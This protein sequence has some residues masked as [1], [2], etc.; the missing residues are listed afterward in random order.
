[1]DT[2]S[3]LRMAATG[4]VDARD[5]AWSRVYDEV[6]VVARAQRRRWSGDWTMETRVLANEVFI[7]VFGDNPPELKDRKHFFTLL[8]KAVRQILVN[9]S[10]SRRAAKRGGGQAQV[11]LSE[12]G[13]LSLEPEVS[14]RILDLHAALKRFESLDERAARIV[15]LRFFA[16][17]NYDEIASAMDVSRATAV[18]DWEAAKVWLHREM[19]GAPA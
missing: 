15:E 7:K 11:T 10:E 4:D 17:L 3:L 6:L 5:Q 18:R 2:I 14:D 16:G 1:M 12:A 8:A 9:Y 19:G 13:G